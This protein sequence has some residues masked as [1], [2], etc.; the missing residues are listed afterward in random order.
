MKEEHKEKIIRV[1]QGVCV[2]KTRLLRQLKTATGTVRSTQ[3]HTAL[4][5]E[6][7]RG[8]LQRGLAQGTSTSGRGRVT[9]LKPTRHT[10]GSV[11]GGDAI[12]PSTA[13]HPRNPTS[14]A[15]G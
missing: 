13:P 4:Y 6:G 5:R 11:L 1:T 2:L 15:A 10:C 8:G 3:C 9:Q 14:P 7:S 12:L